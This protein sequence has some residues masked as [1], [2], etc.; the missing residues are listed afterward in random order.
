MEAQRAHLYSTLAQVVAHTCIPTPTFANSKELLSD[1]QIVLPEHQSK[2]WKPTRIES[3]S[4]HSRCVCD[5]LSWLHV[6]H[7]H[8]PFT[9]DKEGTRLK[10][11]M[12]AAL[13]S[14]MMAK[15]IQLDIDDEAE[16]T[17]MEEAREHAESE[18]LRA[19]Q[20]AES[21]DQVIQQLQAELKKRRKPRKK[22][23][24]R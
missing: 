3:S 1:L 2:L 7:L 19:G 6:I 23:K 18:E 14:C 8:F 17:R 5:I 15:E 10:V 16:K 11:L 13:S 24:R 21:K 12:E 9:D 22:T 20:E 4:D